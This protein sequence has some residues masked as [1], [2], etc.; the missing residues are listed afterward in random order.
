MRKQNIKIPAYK[1]GDLKMNLTSLSGI[2][3]ICLA[4][5]LFFSI[6]INSQYVRVPVETCPGNF[7]LVNGV[8]VHQIETQKIPVCPEGFVSKGSECYL[9]EP[10]LK[11]CPTGFQMQDKQCVKEVIVERENYC[12]DGMEMDYD[13][14]KCYYREE[15][16]AVCPQGSIHFRDSCAIVREPMK[17]CQEPLKFDFSTNM[18]IE[19]KATLPTAACPESFVFETSLKMCIQDHIEPKICPEGFKDIDENNCATWIQPEYIC[20]KGSQLENV[21]HQSLCRYVK[22]SN[23][24]LE[25]PSGFTLEGQV[26][27]STSGI[28]T[29]VCPIGFVEVE[30]QCVNYQEPLF[31]CPEG[32]EKTIHNGNKVCLNTLSV[33]PEISCP[34]I[35]SYF[36]Q[37]SNL[38]ISETTT[39]KECPAN[40]FR[41]KDSCLQKVKGEWECPPGTKYNSESHF[42]QEIIT[43]E[44]NI[45]CPPNSKFDQTTS[46]C[47]GYERN[48]HVCP[49]GYDEVGENECASFV[50]PKRSCKNSQNLVNAQCEEINFSPAEVICP[51][52]SELSNSVCVLTSEDMSKRKCPLNS[53]DSGDYCS[54]IESPEKHCIEGYKFNPETQK[55]TKITTRSPDLVCEEPNTL[56]FL[57]ECVYTETI[58]KVCPNGSREDSL[59]ENFCIMETKP[60]SNCPEGYSLINN[61]CKKEKR[62]EVELNCP[63]GYEINSLDMSC[64]KTI[65]RSQICPPGFLDNGDECFK[66]LKPSSICPEGFGREGKFGDCVQINISES[67]SQ[68]PEGSVELSSGMCGTRKPLPLEYK[69]LKGTKVGDSCLVESF[70]DASYEC[71]KGYYLS[72]IKQCQKL[73]EY[74]CSEVSI[75]SIPCESGLNTINTSS[76]GFYGQNRSGICS[77]IIRNQKTCSRTEAFPPKISCPLGSINIGKEC[78]KKEHLPMT[79][80]CSDHEKTLETC[81]KEFMIPKVNIC[82]PGSYLTEDNKCASI[83][84]KAPEL[85]CEEGYNME[86]GN[87]IQMTSKV[88]PPEGCT[89]RNIVDSL[90]ECPPGFLF[91]D[92]ICIFRHE[93]YPEKICE[94]G[95]LSS[96]NQQVCIERIVK[97]CSHNKCEVIHKQSPELK[98]RENE[99][100]NSKTK[101]CEKVNIGPQILKCVKPFKLIGDQ[102]V[103][104]VSKECSGGNCSVTISIP[105]RITCKQGTLISSNQCEIIKRTPSLLTCPKDF[106]LQ[107]DLCAK[108][109]YKEC[110]NNQCEKKVHYPPIIECPSQ[111]SL[112]PGGNCSKKVQHLPQIKCHLGSSL[113]NSYCIREVEAICPVEGCLIRKTLPPILTCPSGFEKNSQNLSHGGPVCM[114]KLFNNGEISCPKGSIMFNGSCLTYS[115]KECYKDKCEELKTISPTKVCP[116]GTELMNE[117]VCKESEIVPKDMIC[118]EEYILNGDKCVLYKEK[119]CKHKDCKTQK[120]I[121]PEVTCPNGFRLDKAICIWEKYHSTLSSC[122][123]DSMMINGQCFSM[124]KKE[125]PNDTC[126]NKIYFDSFS[127]CP[128]GFVEAG[129]KCIMVEYSG[130]KRICP[131]GL[132]LKKN[133]CLRFAQ[134][135]FKCPIGFME[136]GEKCIKQVKTEPIVTY[137][138]QCVGNQCNLS[139][140]VNIAQQKQTHHHT[141]SHHHKQK[142]HL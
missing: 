74:D 139:S 30:D 5:V 115:V 141:H 52:G 77:Q 110:L 39:E 63:V 125:C 46:S 57:G 105:P 4:S 113:K 116:S 49:P 43:I 28:S 42:C 32:Y 75:V 111:Y 48:L 27:V 61:K 91:E 86:E 135:K 11:E 88:C 36:D 66:T 90:R 50:S 112:F 45:I 137:D 128:K 7:A 104:Q 40:S 97:I 6:Q 138:S 93:V 65:Q 81:F 51:S 68:C 83:Y 100:L 35:Y 131:P 54:V 134:A 26:C 38:C 122:P 95:E 59:N 85:I 21:K 108:Y 44:P 142:K 82:S 15:V 23:P 123:K 64:H 9:A 18:C 20:P 117:N 3:K 70:M 69:C 119:I 120:V 62:A 96:T 2:A 124:L 37:S 106:T 99:S 121:E 132:I 98:C 87:C 24:I 136:E 133:H 41:S 31:H 56:N 109:V 33:E 14:G 126:E 127:R 10:L 114:K 22:Y 80:I 84:R 34:S 1:T 16:K 29:R 89:S 19:R 118:P 130:H 67:K 72:E 94:R 140:S 103:H 73:V 107:D 13:K 55:C 60:K 78:L 76:L 17:T 71:P 58:P 129:K 12:L 47:I 92:G 53:L 8:C 102:C 101:L 79:R 25:C